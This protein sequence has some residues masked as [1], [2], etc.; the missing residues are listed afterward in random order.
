MPMK[1]CIKVTFSLILVYYLLYIVFVIYIY[2]YI[3]HTNVFK[4][5]VCNCPNN[6]FW[7]DNILINFIQIS[8]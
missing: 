4:G 6:I 7:I 8:K 2:I 5:D 1:I 3:Y